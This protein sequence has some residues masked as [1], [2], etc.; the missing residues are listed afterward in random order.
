MFFITLI[1]TLLWPG[2]IQAETKPL[3]ISY[4]FGIFKE[5]DAVVFYGEISESAAFSLVEALSIQKPKTLVMI[6]P[7]GEMQASLI[8]GTYLKNSD[9]E[10]LIR[11]NTECISACAFAVMASKQLQVNGNL[12]FHTPYFPVVSTAD[13]L[14][15]LFLMSSISHVALVEWFLANGYTLEFYRRILEN[16][17]NKTFLNFT[18]TDDLL[19]FKSDDPLA[20]LPDGETPYTV[21]TLE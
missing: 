6:S 18:S 11:E 8:I 9:V 1:L 13:S 17:S 15:D 3:V 21:V 14:N 2:S 4:T 19:K 5:E 7:G 10:V 20:V 16:T 12:L